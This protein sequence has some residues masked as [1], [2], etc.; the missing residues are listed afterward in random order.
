MMGEQKYAISYRN[1]NTGEW[2]L[3][4]D[5]SKRP[6]S[7]DSWAE[8]VEHL[9]D[10]LDQ[11]SEEDEGR[12]TAGHKIVRLVPKGTKR[13]RRVFEGTKKVFGPS[14]LIESEK[15]AV[16]GNQLLDAVPFGAKVKVIVSWR[17][18]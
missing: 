12:A 9:S 14:H 13:A 5:G 18:P 17:T 10:W 8:A 4:G 16:S 15:G 6:W 1:E 3:V 7:T 11:D 2:R